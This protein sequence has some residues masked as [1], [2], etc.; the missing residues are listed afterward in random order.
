MCPQD[1][2]CVTPAFP[3]QRSSINLSRT[4]I[5]ASRKSILQASG[6]RGARSSKPFIQL[7]LYTVCMY[8]GIQMM[9]IKEDD[10]NK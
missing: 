1:A 6:G 5:N 10:E 2:A 7:L 9:K 3:M 8:A 4:T